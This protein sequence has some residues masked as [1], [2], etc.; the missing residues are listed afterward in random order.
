MPLATKILRAGE[1]RL[2]GAAGTL[3]LNFDQ[4]QTKQ[5]FFFTGT[6]TC[7]EFAF[8]EPPALAT[9]DALVLDDGSLIEIVADAESVIEAR[10]PDPAMLARLAWLLGNRHLPVQ[11]FANRLRMRPN[12]DMEAVL[13]G[14]G[15]KARALVAP[16]EP[17]GAQL[18]ASAHSHDHPH[19]Q[20]HHHAHDHGHYDNHDHGHHGHA[21]GDDHESHHHSERHK[22]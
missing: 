19:G 13:A 14:I 2:G 12:A 8:A 22:A 7:I 16:F 11:I 5:G 4:R 15:I 20:E 10:I 6:G 18:A 3:I 21:H 9:D 1:A 17:D